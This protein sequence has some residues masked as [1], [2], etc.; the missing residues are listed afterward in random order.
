MNHAS[1]TVTDVTKDFI[2]LVDNDIGKSVTNDAD[3]VVET[4]AKRFGDSRRVLYR[5]SMGNWDELKHDKGVF[6][7]YEAIPATDRDAIREFLK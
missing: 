2:F 5:D 3:W 6:E 7:S 1:F 4:V